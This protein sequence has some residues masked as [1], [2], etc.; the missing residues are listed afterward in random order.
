M[1]MGVML[2]TK[3]VCALGAT[4][5]FFCQLCT[6]PS[7]YRLGCRKNRSTLDSSLIFKNPR[8]SLEK[9]FFNGPTPIL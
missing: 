2:I 4:V 6:N 5:V 8:L 3:F 9:R 1:Q 7:S